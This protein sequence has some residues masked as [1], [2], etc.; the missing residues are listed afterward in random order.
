[1]APLQEIPLLKTLL[2]CPKL[3]VNARGLGGRTYLY[4]C[5]LEQRLGLKWF[6]TVMTRKDVDV[7]IGDEA[8]WNPICLACRYAH[9]EI[10]VRLLAHP[11]IDVN[12]KK[13]DGWTPFML[14]AAN[15]SHRI[16][17]LLLNVQ[18]KKVDL[19]MKNNN[20]QTALDLAVAFSKPQVADLLRRQ[21]RQSRKRVLI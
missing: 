3:D 11:D 10:L 6:N 19:Q 9:E 12:W 20:G 7:N 17:N 2:A 1:M 14:A 15:G 5:V 16:V 8:G 4:S 13:T 18:G 21:G